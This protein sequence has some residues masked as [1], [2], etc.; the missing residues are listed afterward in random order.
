MAD[1]AVR[2][3]LPT[4]AAEIARIQR[5]TWQT[6]YAKILPAEVLAGLDVE[7]TERLWLEAVTSGPATVL[8]ATEGEWVVGF[9]AAG[10][11]PA[12]E[13]AAADGAMPVDAETTALVSV[14]LVEPRWGRRGHAGRLL[15]T[16]AATMRAAG[17][18]RGVTWVA[19]A[20]QASMN[21]FRAAG[22]DTDGTVR[23]LDAGG[24]PLRE[25]RLTGSLELSLVE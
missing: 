1:A 12:E 8:V 11:A 16:A 25:F 5:I 21:F 20:D 18:Q 22:W 14:L 23:T 6:A 4:D 9:C 15:G 13:I 17:A 10:P 19:E 24:R 3:A 2:P 7:E